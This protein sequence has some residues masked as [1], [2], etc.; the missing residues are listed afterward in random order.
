M[1]KNYQCY[2]NINYSSLFAVSGIHNGLLLALFKQGADRPGG[3]GELFQSDRRGQPSVQHSI[4]GYPRAVHAEP[5]GPGS[6]Q[7]VG[8][9]RRVFVPV[10]S[11]A[12]QTLEAFQ[13]GGLAERAVE[14]AKGHD[15]DD[16]VH[17]GRYA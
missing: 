2:T 12:G 3:Q 4:R 13:S 6:L 1:G 10:L 11:H 9:G 16:V 17:A 15:H 8:R 14:L 7:A 5:T